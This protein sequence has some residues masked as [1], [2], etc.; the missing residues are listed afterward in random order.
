MCLL[1]VAVLVSSVQSVAIGI[2]AAP[3]HAI[4]KVSLILRRMPIDLITKLLNL[5]RGL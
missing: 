3:L 1:V 5:D 2:A 4:V